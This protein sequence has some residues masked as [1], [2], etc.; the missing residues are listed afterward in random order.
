MK[1]SAKFK[2]Y[3]FDKDNNLIVSFTVDSRF[4][5][6]VQE[7]EAIHNDKYFE[8]KTSDRVAQKSIK[9]N[10]AVWQL[11][12]MINIEQDGRSTKENENELYCQLISIAG[13][14]LDYLQG[15][16][17]IE[18]Q[19]NNFYRVVKVREKRIADNGV[20]TCMFECYR[21]LSQFNKEET[22]QFIE[23]ILDYAANL[24]L[25]ITLETEYL[26]NILEKS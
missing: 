23:T 8:L 12:K 13:I 4:I 22:N 9:Q 3:S 6:Q 16:T 7:L 18:A 21:G 17:E 14:K 15:L 26:R 2:D 25:E 20:E 24:G 10:N 19:L 5:S 11:I 1:V